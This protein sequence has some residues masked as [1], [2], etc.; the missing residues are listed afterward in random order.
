MLILMKKKW[1]KEEGKEEI[2]VKE[3]RP[4]LMLL[5]MKMRLR[6]SLNLDR[7]LEDNKVGLMN[8]ERSNLMSVLQEVLEA[9][10][11]KLEEL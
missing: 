9:R 3:C 11:S 8:R 10:R 6:S 5:I 4:S 1:Y 7:D 2:K